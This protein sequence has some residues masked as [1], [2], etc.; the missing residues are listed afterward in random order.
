VVASIIRLLYL[1]LRWRRAGLDPSKPPWSDNQQIVLA[2]WHDRLLM[3]PGNYLRARQRRRPSAVLISQHRDG[4]LVAAAMARLGIGSVAGSSTRG[5]LG[6]IYNLR[7]AASTG[8]DIGITPDGP[9][10]PRHVCKKGIV[11]FAQRTGLPIYPISFSAQKRWE[12]RSWDR[13]IVPKP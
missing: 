2:F 8:A 11:A 13:M 4:R 12:L 7:R 3:V 6:A 9:R 1:S 10:G 5:G